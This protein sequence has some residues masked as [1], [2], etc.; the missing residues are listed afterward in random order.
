L[1][2]KVAEEVIGLNGGVVSLLRA[3]EAAAVEREDMLVA[4]LIAII[5]E[6]ETPV[7]FAVGQVVVAA[8]AEVL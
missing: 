6:E 1:V 2:I 3:V 8:E 4:K 5:A 7:S